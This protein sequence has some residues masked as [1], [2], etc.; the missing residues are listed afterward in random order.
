MD[1]IRT[2]GLVKIY[3]GRF[4]LGPID[5]RV[6]AGDVLGIMGPNGAGKT[7]LLKLVWGFLRPDQG[8]ISLFHLQPHLNQVSVRQRAGYLSES[9]HFY[10]WMTARMHL[11][12]ISQ[13]YEGWDRAHA[14]ALLARF[15]IDPKVQIRQLSRGNR[16]KLALVAA[17]AHHPVLLLLDEPTAGLDP[18]VRRDILTFLKDLS[19]NHG[20]GIVLSSHISDDLDK[21]ADW[22]L[23]LNGGR[24]VEYAH[25]PALVQDYGRERMEDIFLEAMAK[26][27]RARGRFHSQGL[28]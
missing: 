22:V 21:L 19:K 27:D 3:G 13:F 24:V 14:Q 6:D 28:G 10:S 8:S 23:M 5:L 17:A 2:E 26:T 11:D 20:V 18:L 9:P 4:T 7:T 15:G 25:A 1:F 12:F 16:T